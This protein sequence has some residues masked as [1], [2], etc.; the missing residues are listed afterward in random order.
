[1]KSGYHKLKTA[2]CVAVLTLGLAACSGGHSDADLD[3]AAA[4]A[5]EE[6]NAAAAEA[7]RL[8]AV[9]AELKKQQAIDEAKRLAAEAVAAAEKMARA[10]AQKDVIAKAIADAKAAVAMVKL[11]ASDADITAATEAIEAITTAIEAADAVDDRS[12][13]SAQVT[14]LNDSLAAA[15]DFVQQDRDAKTMALAEEQKL[16]IA[17]AIT[18]AEKAIALVNV[19]GATDAEIEAA[20]MAAGAAVQ[21]AREAITD[22]DADADAGGVVDD[23]SMYTTQVDGLE[24]SLGTATVMAR[25][26]YQSGVIMAALQTAN[27]AV[28][29]V[30]LDATPDEILDATTAVQAARDAI[31]KA[32]DVVDTSMYATKVAGLETS[33]TKATELV[34]QD[35]AAKRMARA[36]DQKDVIADA[37]AD[38]KA[39]VARVV[40][41]VDDGVIIAAE[42]AI[43]DAEA[44]IATADAVDDTSK[45]TATATVNDLASGLVA[46]KIAVL[47][48]RAA[49]VAIETQIASQ[50]TMATDA[51]DAAKMAADN[52]EMAA[53]DA[54]TARTNIATMQTNENSGMHAKAARESA[55]TAMDAYMDA[56][57]A[58]EA[59]DE[60]ATVVAAVEA[61]VDA[62]GAEKIAEE[63]EMMAGVAGVSAEEAVANELLIVGTMKTVGDTTIDAA[64]VEKNSVTTGSGTTLQTETTGLIE[65]ET[66]TAIGEAIIGIPYAA[67]PATSYEQAAEERPDLEIGK[68]LDSSDDMTRLMLVTHYA[69]T[70]MVRVFKEGTGGTLKSKKANHIGITDGDETTDVPLRSAGMFY[71]AGTG[72]GD[73]VAANEIAEAAVPVEVFWYPEP[74]FM[75]T[76]DDDGVRYVTLTT[77]ST[78]A[79]GTTTYTYA[80]GADITAINLPDGDDENGDPDQGQVFSAIPAEVAYQHIEF[81]VWAGLGEASSSGTQQIAD[82]GIGFLQN[83]DDS[84]MTGA[85]MPNVGKATYNG[86]WVAAVRKAHT[87]A[88]DGSVSLEYG[89]AT[90]RA[91][92]EEA[93]IEATL[94]GLATLDGS[95]DGS[96]FSG[97]TATVPGSSQHGLTSGGSF[98]GSFSGGFY[99]ERGA[100]AGGIF[101]F[102][103][104]T[105]GEFLGAFGGAKEKPD[106]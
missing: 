62:K 104:K 60:A 106:G 35:R 31:D 89:A 103:G 50:R 29:A 101:D 80:I 16:A 44:A 25:S 68:T 17:G 56:K 98:T 61:R 76:D 39:A 58:S 10:T 57:A 52:A 78:D 88:G 75:V 59:A 34:H 32:V 40:D 36:D 100:E 3:A 90:V 46:T 64:V 99:G 105:A 33:L 41:G 82:L 69:G 97:K 11:N 7:A 63:Q 96:M 15:T 85:D 84:G 2:C 48:N 22:A 43:A 24:A 79:T 9:A 8:A 74:G 95:I 38:A 30:D 55:D 92:F 67:D 20:A 12:M 21:A 72:G 19:D 70:Q 71:S 4:E 66:P 42:K 51:V 18:D 81:G 5:R 26:A 83:H 87:V 27:D 53:Y 13:Y 65:T 94:T 93:T 28:D 54:E 102:D 23:T 14:L 77:A 1:M 73:L 91:D 6:A 86:N 45:D 47:T 37:I 49:Q